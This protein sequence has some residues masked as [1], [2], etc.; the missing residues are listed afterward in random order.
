[1]IV[2]K[3]GIPANNLKE[4][5][6]WLKANNATQG[7]SG[8]GTISHVTGA[9]FQKQTHTKFQFI[10]YRGVGPAMQ[11]LVAGQIDLQCEGSSNFLAHVR[12][13]TIKAYAVMAKTHLAVAPD[14]PTVD[15]S[16]L[17]GLHASVWYGLWAP[18]A[19]P[20]DVIAKVNAAVIDAL[21]SVPVRQ[22]LA[23]LGNE[24]PPRDQQTPEALA[25]HQKTEM[26]RW[27]PIIKAANIKGE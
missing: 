5:I 19:T 1:M 11:D 10:P 6:A 14:I 3:K 2:G 15:E 20:K 23:E 4:L 12:A 8:V 22:R 9:V 21:A 27:W 16:G 7:T 25:A 24:I 17:P 26:E 13:G 18:K